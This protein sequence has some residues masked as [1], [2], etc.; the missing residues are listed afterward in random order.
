MVKK[1]GL[2]ILDM[3]CGNKKRPGTIGVDNN[4]R[5]KGDVNHD[6]NSFPYPFKKS[7][8]DKV[9]LDNCLEHLEN[10][11][12]VME[13]IHR[14]LKV[15]GMVKIIAPY[16]RSPSAFHDPT[17]KTFYTVESFSY[18]DP[19]H[20]ICIRYDYTKSYFNIKKII[21]H[22]NLKSGYFKSSLALF[23]NR[24]PLIYENYISSFFALHEI[25]FRLE[26]I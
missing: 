9:Y 3:G 5:V 24:W 16:F 20:P 21:F 13:E 23:A 22:E 11:L 6:L 2:I 10:P 26:K 15:G 14:I 18:F 1:T 17:H 8:I 7:S 12:K 25:T 19:N 4:P